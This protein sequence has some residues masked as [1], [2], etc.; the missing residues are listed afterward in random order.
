[1]SVTNVLPS[2]CRFPPLKAEDVRKGDREMKVAWRKK[3]ERRA[4]VERD[5]E[6]QTQRERDSEREI[7]REKEKIGRAHV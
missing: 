3:G 4:D 2:F 1:M 5:S 7:Q 6:R